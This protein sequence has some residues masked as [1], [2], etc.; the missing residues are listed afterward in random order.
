MLLTQSQERYA[1]EA[2][3]LAHHLRRTW[4][5]ST[6]PSPAAPEA[7]AHTSSQARPERAMPQRSTPDRATRTSESSPSVP[8]RRD[9]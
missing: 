4:E 2:R 5:P 1:R 3:I 9:K 6:P 7:E 8:K